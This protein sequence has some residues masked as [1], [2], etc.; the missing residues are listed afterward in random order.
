[1]LHDITPF[2][3]PPSGLQARILEFCLISILHIS[4]LLTLSTFF[5]PSSGYQKL[6]T[7]Q[8]KVD[9]VDHDPL[10]SATSFSF[11]LDIYIFFSSL[12]IPGFTTPAR[13]PFE[14][15]PACF[16]TVLIFSTHTGG[17]LFFLPVPC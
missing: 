12:F 16:S 2:F 10:D 14:D 15:Y 5:P 7:K 9:R 8:Q 6:P 13:L 1:M 4:G 3:S 11:L 17:P